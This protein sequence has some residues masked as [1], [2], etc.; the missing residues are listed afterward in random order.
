M[1]PEDT[2]VT[3]IEDPYQ[4]PNCRHGWHGLPCKLRGLYTAPGGICPCPGSLPQDD[5]GEQLRV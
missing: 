3:R 4:C 2:P 1:R 5:A